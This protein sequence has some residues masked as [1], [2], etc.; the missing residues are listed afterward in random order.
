V[1]LDNTNLNIKESVEQM[2]SILNDPD[3]AIR[4]R[5]LAEKYLSLDSGV[6]QYIK[7]YE[8]LGN[9]SS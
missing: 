6:E 2:R 1:F 9:I 5:A 3:T 8:N 4:C 7:M